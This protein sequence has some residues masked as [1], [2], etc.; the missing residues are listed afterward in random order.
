MEPTFSGPTW[1][2]TSDGA[3]G[4]PARTL[5][6]QIAGWCAEYLLADDGG[7][8]RFTREQLRFILWWYAIDKRG[9][10]RYRRGVLRRAKGWGTRRAAR[11]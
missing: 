3:W 10:F 4:L 5:G 8:W 2:R 6:W 11:W 1:S 7:P 9:R